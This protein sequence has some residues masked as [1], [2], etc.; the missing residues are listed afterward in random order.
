MPQQHADSPEVIYEVLSNDEAFMSLVGAVTFKAGDTVL[1]AI[2]IVTPGAQLPSV[3]AV[4]GLEVV[5]HDISNFNRRFYITQDTDVTATWKVFLLAWSP[6]SGATLSS[7]AK[8][9]ME[10]FS[11]ALTI[12]TVPVPGGIGAT[13]QVLALIPSDSVVL[14]PVD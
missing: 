3:K 10:L 13:A 12:E 14:A 5:I 4:S 6:A 1:D 8:R 7:A 2:S 9:I 11:K